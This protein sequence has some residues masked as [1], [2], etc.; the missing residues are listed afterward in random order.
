MSLSFWLIVNDAADVSG[1]EVEELGDFVVVVAAKHGADLVVAE[2]AQAGEGRGEILPCAAEFLQEGLEA[3][4]AKGLLKYLH[5]VVAHGAVPLWFAENF[6]KS[7]WPGSP[8]PLPPRG[9]PAEP[10]PPYGP[11]CPLLYMP[12]LIVTTPKYIDTQYIFNA[13]PCPTIPNE[14]RHLLTYP[15]ILALQLRYNVK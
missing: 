6:K 15:I 10:P 13:R 4:R 11:P 12:D 7:L 3:S 2:S 5:G 9:S 1:G 8:P 14:I